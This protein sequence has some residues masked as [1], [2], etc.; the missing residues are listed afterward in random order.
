MLILATAAVPIKTAFRIH[1]M[2]GSFD[3][4]KEFRSGKLFVDFRDACLYLFTG[5]YKRYKNDKTF[6]SPNAFAASSGNSIAEFGS[7]SF[8]TMK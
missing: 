4:F 5:D 7:D 1:S 8:S 3:D 6:K 2:G